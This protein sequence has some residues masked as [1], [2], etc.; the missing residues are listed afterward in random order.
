V[1]EACSVSD[2]SNGLL[3]LSCPRCGARALARLADGK[4]ELG[5]LI[6]EGAG[7]FRPFAVAT[8]PDLYVRRDAGW[9]DCW[10]RKVY[11]RFPVAV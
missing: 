8:E 5:E 4:L 2:P 11:R 1:L 7:G 10:H 6:A 9:V 3:R